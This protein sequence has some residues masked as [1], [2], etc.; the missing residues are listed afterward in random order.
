VTRRRHVCTLVLAAALAACGP[1]RTQLVAT[2]PAPH[3]VAATLA[4]VP[5][6]VLVPAIDRR[7]QVE[8]DGRGA[9]PGFFFAT[10]GGAMSRFSGASVLDG[11]DALGWSDSA[12]GGQLGSASTAVASDVGRA[13]ASASG[14]P[15][16]YAVASAADA[17]AAVPD[18]TVVVTVVIDHLTQVTPRNA[19]FSQTKHQEGNYEVTTTTSR[20]ETFGPFWTF[21]FA[22]ELAEVR[23]RRIGR[24][25]VRH[26]TATSTS[27][28]GYSD[29]VGQAAYQVVEAVAAEW[30]PAAV[31]P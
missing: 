31:T 6:F 30:S 13:L 10:T 14:R 22:V 2:P 9:E 27:P 11:D 25:L 8:R 26:A 23:D 20:S 19:D 15:V 24:R 21:T 16:Q 1:S 28:T 3:P 12:F 29:A 4:A 7:P 18:G 17:A 5:G